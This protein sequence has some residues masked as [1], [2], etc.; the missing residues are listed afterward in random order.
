MNN[1]RRRLPAT[2]VN[3][4]RSSAAVCITLG[5]RTVDSTRWRQILAENREFCLPHLHSTH[6]SPSRGSPSEY[7]HNVWRQ[8]DGEKNEDTFTRFDRR[9]ERDGRTS[10]VHDRRTD[11][12]RRH[13]P[14][15]YIA[16]RVNGTLNQIFTSLSY[17][18]FRKSL[19]NRGQRCNR[20]L[21]QSETATMT[22]TIHLQWQHRC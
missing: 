12:A 5:G 18:R 17:V 4:P 13:R 8:A 20:Q 22:M 15:L 3:S 16:S 2:I 19:I 10:E 21:L 1:K 14:R 11:T 6:P 9:H 7:C